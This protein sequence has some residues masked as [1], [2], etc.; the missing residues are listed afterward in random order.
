YM[1]TAGMRIPAAL[2]CAVNTDLPGQICAQVTQNVYDK[3]TG[4]YLLIPQF[5]E[6]IGTYDSH[7]AIGQERIL[8]A[9]SRL[10]FEDGSHLNLEGMPGADASGAAGFDADVNNHYGRTLATLAAASVFSAGLQISQGKQQSTN[11][12]QT[13]QQQVA[14]AIGQNIAQTGAQITQRQLQI[15][16]TL[17]RERGYKFVVQVTKDIIFPGPYSLRTR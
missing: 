3:M 2:G 14:A 6:I 8:V 7:I 4:K 10:Q 16:P 5:T 11:G 9:W 15:Q 1:L 12:T 17:S 13:P